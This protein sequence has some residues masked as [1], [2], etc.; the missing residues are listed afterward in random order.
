MNKQER[1]ILLR[2]LVINC[3]QIPTDI[4]AV[5]RISKAN[6]LII[7]ASNQLESPEERETEIQLPSAFQPNQVIGVKFRNGDKPFTATVRGVHFYPGKVKYD[8]GLWLGDGS[9]DNPESE[10]RI[11]NVDSVFCATPQL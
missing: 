5:A 8:V 9:V 7:A 11:Y 2:N 10:T 4:P 6:E 1:E 3:Q